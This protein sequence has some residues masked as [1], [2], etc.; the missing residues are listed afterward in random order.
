MK[1]LGWLSIF[2]LTLYATVAF[3]ADVHLH[4]GNDQSALHCQLCQISNLSVTQTVALHAS[5]QIVD[6][7]ILIQHQ[8]QFSAMETV[9]ASFGRAP[10][11][12]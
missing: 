1:R 6:L 4:S 5:P 7:G 11:L 8:K 3:A 10:P 12:S 9:H 2:V